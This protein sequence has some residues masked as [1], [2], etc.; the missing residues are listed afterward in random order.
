MRNRRP[1]RSVRRLRNKL[2]S[3]AKDQT[4]VWPFLVLWGARRSPRPDE[5][6]IRQQAGHRMR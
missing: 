3:K 2:K 6:A 1:S 4:L 5:A